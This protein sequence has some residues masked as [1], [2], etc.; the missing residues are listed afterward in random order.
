MK[1]TFPAK[2]I[3][4]G[5]MPRKR[6]E[7]FKTAFIKSFDSLDPFTAEFPSKELE[8]PNTEKIVVVNS[9]SNVQYFLEGNDI[10]FSGISQFSIEKKG[11]IVELSVK[12]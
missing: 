5:R 10:V 2:S 4:F 9:D 1:E 11:T 12:K 3:I 6:P 7:E 8:Y